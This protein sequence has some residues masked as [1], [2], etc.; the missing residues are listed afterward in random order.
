[1]ENVRKRRLTQ[2]PDGFL[3]DVAD[4]TYTCTIC[5]EQSPSGETWWFP[6]ALWCKECKRNIDNG[7]IPKLF[8]H[9][10]KYDQSWFTKSEIEYDYNLKWNQI[11]K[12]EKEGSL[13]PRNLINS[14]G[15]NYCTIYLLKENK[16]FFKTHQRVSKGLIKSTVIGDNGEEITL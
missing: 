5:H 8:D 1:M 10:D 11:K 3:L 13:N 15:Q 12:L 6:N 16:E 2:E 14:L 4:R 7:T 9:E